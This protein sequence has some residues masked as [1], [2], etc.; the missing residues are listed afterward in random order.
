MRQMGGLMKKIPI[1]FSVLA[2]AWVAIAGIPPFSGFFSKDEILLA[3]HHHHPWMYWVG[4]VTAGM[5]AFYV[6]RAMFMTFFGKYRGHH[7]PHESPPI[8]WAPLAVL[9]ALSLAG[10]W[11]FKVPHYLENMFPLSQEP[12]DMTLV[13]ISVGAGAL[14]IGLAYVFYVLSPGIPAA[15]AGALGPI[16]KLVYNKYF[17]DEVYDATII[18]PMVSGSRTVLWRIV[19]AGLIDGIVNGTGALARGVGGILRTLQSG[20]IRSYAAWVTVGSVLVI[21]ALSVL[22]GGSK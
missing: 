13:A 8:M 17:V 9:A 10:G 2:C 3:A 6:S 19:D 7:H 16:Y 15:I 12:H 21:V 18:N 11:Y 14:G 4:V 20:Q 22:Q 1:T 5:T